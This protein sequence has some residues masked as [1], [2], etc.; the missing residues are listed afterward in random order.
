MNMQKTI[1]SFIATAFSLAL[2]TPAYS[3]RDYDWPSVTDY[4]VTKERE[5]LIGPVQSVKRE[6][7]KF[8]SQSGQWI[9]KSRTS[10]STLVYDQNGNLIMET[11]ERPDGSTLIFT[12]YTLDSKGKLL[13]KSMAGENITFSYDAA[14]RLK[15]VLRETSK[16]IYTYN[17]QGRVIEEVHLPAKGQHEQ[18]NKYIY[19][20]DLKGRITEKAHYTS[21]GGF[22]GK[23]VY[24]YDENGDLIET[25]NYV[26]EKVMYD[27]WVYKYNDI[28]NRIE[29]MNYRANNSIIQKHQY[30]YDDRNNR[31]S[32]TFY[33]TKDTISSK[34]SDKYEYDSVGNWIKKEEKL[35]WTDKPGN[36]SLEV[37]YR[38]IS[39]YPTR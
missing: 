12:K 27:R 39:Y 33:N 1:Q 3:T 36:D 21:D 24:T 28:G 38:T 9:E 32:V 31:T 34:Q 2:I 11:G 22:A 15:E 30:T 16:E 35:T 8:V 10:L 14:G 18:T 17:E 6:M 5:S 19:R 23:T 26:A 29:A 25:A 37:T 20:Y 4:L 13:S 7:V